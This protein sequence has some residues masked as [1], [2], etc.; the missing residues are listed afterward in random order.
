MPTRAV[1]TTILDQTNVK[2]S[3]AFESLVQQSAGKASE[4]EAAAVAKAIGL[5]EGFG[6]WKG[7]KKEGE[8]GLALT[9]TRS[10]AI[11]ESPSPTGPLKLEESVLEDVPKMEDLRGSALSD[12]GHDWEEAENGGGAESKAFE[13]LDPTNCDSLTGPEETEISKGNESEV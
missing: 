12:A 13:E 11:T 1:E 5:N 3:G 6:V 7:F 4:D 10:N 8:D 9:K 2:S